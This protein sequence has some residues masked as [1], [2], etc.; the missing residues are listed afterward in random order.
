MNIAF[1]QNPCATCYL[2]NPRPTFMKQIEQKLRRS[3]GLDPGSIGSGLIE[4]AIRL[5]MKEHALE[6][7][8][9]Y[10]RLIE[11]HSAEWEK[12]LE[13]V[14]VTETWFFRDGSPFHALAQLARDQ[15]L[16]NHP[17]AP[18]HILSVP[19]SSGEEPYSIAMALLDAGI[20]SNR[21]H[22]DAVDLST[23][24][25]A[26]ARAGVYGKNSFRGKD[27]AF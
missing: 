9:D 12:L 1:S 23:Q 2:P 25:L 10:T 3:I 15:W 20:P 27:L 14:V 26:R 18:I 22:I 16:P 13:S 11:T 7:V 5:R 17:T 8:E 19:C 4:R 6:R 24:A 21:F